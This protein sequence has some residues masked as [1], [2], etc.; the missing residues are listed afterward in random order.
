LFILKSPFLLG[1]QQL[2]D[3]ACFNLFPYERAIV[4]MSRLR[5]EALLIKWIYGFS[6]EDLGFT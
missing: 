4:I 6:L 1:V 2:I 5:L 3:G